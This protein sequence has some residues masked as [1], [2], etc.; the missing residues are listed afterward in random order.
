VP[1]DSEYQSINHRKP[2]HASFPQGNVVMNI[3]AYKNTSLKKEFQQDV[4]TK[5][6]AKK[7]VSLKTLAI[8]YCLETK[9]LN[10]S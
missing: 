7:E 8:L 10:Q 1:L 2:F 6:S 5:A 9:Q 3:R 4:S